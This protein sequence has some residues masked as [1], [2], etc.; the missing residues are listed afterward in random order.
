L[1]LDPKKKKASLPIE[2]PWLHKYLTA[3]PDA[4]GIRR[5]GPPV[6]PQPTIS[7]LPG[8][9]P[10]ISD[11]VTIEDALASRGKLGG[12]SLGG[13]ALDLFPLTAAARMGYTT[14]KQ[15]QRN[16]KA[17]AG[18]T[19]AL[20]MLPAVPGKGAAAEEA[21]RIASAAFKLPGGKILTG[22]SHP[23]I[24]FEH[25][26]QKLLS[27]QQLEKVRDGFVTTSGKFVSREQGMRLA[28]RAGQLTPETIAESP[29]ELHVGDFIEPEGPLSAAMGRARDRLDKQ[30]LSGEPI[31]RDLAPPVSA[32]VFKAGRETPFP[33][34][35]RKQNQFNEVDPAQFHGSLKT[36]ATARPDESGFITWRTPDEMKAEGMKTY[37]SPDRKTGYA[38]HPES[39]DIRNVFNHGDKGKGADA[40]AHALSNGGKVLDAFDTNLGNFYRDF[41][42][43]E[44]ERLPWNDEYRP[45]SW[46]EEKYGRPDVVMMQHPQAGQL[47][48][49]EFIS[50]YSAARSERKGNWLQ[51]HI[52]VEEPS[53]LRKVEPIPA[54]GG[55]PA[56]RDLPRL[57]GK[58]LGK[59]QDVEDLA[60]KTY[61]SPRFREW[62]NAGREIPGGPNWYDT[63]ATQQKAI[64]ALGDTEGPAAFRDLMNFM[65][66]STAMSRPSNNLRRASWWRGLHMAGMLDPESLLDETLAAPPGMG[67]IAQRAHHHA[68]AD[69]VQ[70]GEINPLSNPKPAS[71]V[72]NLTG[73]DRPYT[74]DTRMGTATLRA[75]PKMELGIANNGAVAPRSWAYAPMER[76]FQRAAHEYHAQG[77][78]HDVP[79]GHD[80]TATAQAQ[81]WGGIGGWRPG[82][83]NAGSFN[84]VFDALLSHSAKM[85]GVTPGE[86]NK[87]LWQGNPFELPL[88]SPMLRK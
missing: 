40:V 68:V 12:L 70:R 77:L 14:G 65:G 4:T 84:S 50:R 88:N 63:R 41:G 2:D 55:A 73:N 39:G 54:A 69:L 58:D 34:Q 86:A 18:L 80:P 32:D 1:P 87:L 57:L 20:A 52:S 78:L 66:A 51:P 36:F 46:N 24:F 9:R 10:N 59:V 75:E 61:T 13:L 71:F 85:W 56:Q 74:N 49:D 43:K 6:L 3:E 33:Y 45:A 31:S 81:I 72:E 60:Y 27:P 47:S 25:D 53:I 19:A 11:K 79:A 29:K 64:D 15:V 22:A 26:L 48:P 28:K 42:F 23:E 8:S 16:E 35:L 7:G 83:D 37:L 67:H 82:Q 76:A 21:E 5:P 62:L 44:T 17:A 30:L 38:I